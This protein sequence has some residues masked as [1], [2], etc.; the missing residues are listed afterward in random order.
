MIRLVYIGIFLCCFTIASSQTQKR[1]LVKAGEIPEKTIPIEEIYFFP[2]FTQGTAILKNGSKS[3]QRFNYN[4]L[5]GE[6]QFISGNDTLSLAEP[7]LV[8]RV[9]IDSTVYYFDKGYLRQLLTSGKY[10]LAVKENIFVGDRR[11]AGAYGGTSG[12]SAIDNYSNVFRDGRGFQLE[13]REDVLFKKDYLLFIGDAYSH[14]TIADKKGFHDVFAGKRNDINE[15]IK[16][17]KINFNNT[18]DVKKLFLYC[19]GF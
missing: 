13:L 8:Q 10:T 2:S 3:T 6:L 16:L 9:N 14:F 7:A 12:T 18:D 1:F 17:E 4:C 5:L 11:K 15:Y 19:T